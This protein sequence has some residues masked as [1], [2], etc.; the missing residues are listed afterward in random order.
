MLEIFNY[1]TVNES[2][3]GYDSLGWVEMNPISA[4]KSVINTEE[5]PGPMQ[6]FRG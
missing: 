5:Q 3:T 1:G 4:F 6:Y 2:N